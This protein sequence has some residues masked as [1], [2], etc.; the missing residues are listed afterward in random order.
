[1][2]IL[3]KR[4]VAAGSVFCTREKHINAPMMRRKF[5]VDAGKNVELYICG[6]GFYELY[7]NGVHITKGKF[8]PYISN[9]DVHLHYDKYDLTPYLRAGENVI[10]LL[11]GNGFLNCIGGV[12]WSFEQAS[13][14]SAPK[15]A[16]SVLID[17]ELAFEAD[18][19]FVCAPSA[20]TFDDLRM[21]EYYDA[22]LEQK[23]WCS[24]D[25][26]DR[27]WKPAVAAETPKGDAV[28]CTAEPIRLMREVT[29]VSIWRA[30]GGYVFDFGENQSGAWRIKIKGEKGQHL[31]FQHGEVLTENRSVYTRNAIS[32]QDNLALIQTDVYICRGDGDYEYYEPHFTYHGF[33]YVFVEGIYEHQVNTDTLTMLVYHSAFPAYSELRTDNEIVNKIQRMVRNSDLSNFYY[34]PTDCPQR[35][36]N[37]WTGDASLSAEQMLYNFDCTVSLRAWLEHMRGLQ[38]ESGAIPCICPT[39]Q[40]GYAWGTGP[41]FDR[42]I[43]E[44]PYQMYRFSGNPE[45]VIE[46]A[47]AI[48]KYVNYLQTRKNENGLYAFGLPDWCECLESAEHICSTPLEVSDTLICI[49]MYQKIEKMFCAVGLV[50]DAQKCADEAGVLIKRFR[51]RY[52]DEDLYISCHTQTA[53]AEAICFNVFTEEEKPAAIR[54]LVSLINQWGHFKTGIFGARVLFRTLVDYGEAEL[55][56]KLITQDR[57]PSY[58]KWADFGMTTL[59]ESF[60]ETYDGSIFPKNGNRVLSYNH[61][62]WGDVS[63][64][65]YRYILGMDINPTYCNANHIHIDPVCFAEINEAYGK[66]ERNGRVLEF[67]ATKKEKCAMIRI[68]QNTGFELTFGADVIVEDI[69]I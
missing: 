14:R 21:G 26:D 43:V 3:S 59:A 24:V 18:E 48:M 51:E 29:A 42:V 31:K 38:K 49:D 44:L 9:P 17:G 36:K 54:N 63:G 1:M 53:Q 69:A 47:P 58:R 8:A 33:R 52:L 12:P 10:G 50:Q 7:I 55:A 61:H 13:Y 68:I 65:F 60:V 40:W 56:Y 27:A 37:G 11:L 67:T 62:M 22:R 16:L 45:I 20:I 5:S 6:L 30:E 39:D 46:N 34:F 19:R 57:F 2:G 15:V 32:P 41:G 4:F 25:F 35:E 66:Y 28:L 64:W 23:D